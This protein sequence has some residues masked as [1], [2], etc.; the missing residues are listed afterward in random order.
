[1]VFAAELKIARDIVVGVASKMFVRV[2]ET[3]FVSHHDVK[4]DIDLIDDAIEKTIQSDCSAIKSLNSFIHFPVIDGLHW[5]GHLLT[6]FCRKYSRRYRFLD[7]LPEGWA[8]CVLQGGI[9]SVSS[10]ITDFKTMVVQVAKN[11]GVRA[12]KEAVNAFLYE[13]KFVSRRTDGVV[14]GIVN[15]LRLLEE[16]S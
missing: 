9:V 11:S 7:G 4:F 2:S 1:M 3:E 10:G 8:S 14:D 13:T 15:A 12:N 16:N 6:S 5:N